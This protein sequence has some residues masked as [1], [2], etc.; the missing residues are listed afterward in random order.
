M[1]LLALMLVGCNGNGIFRSHTQTRTSE[2]E[3]VLEDHCS[4][5]LFVLR[6]PGNHN[7]DA[8][9]YR[10]VL[11]EKVGWKGLFVINKAGHSELYWGRYR[12][13][14]DKKA[15]ANL[16]T[17]KKYRTSNGKALFAGAQIVPVPGKNVGPA[18]WDLINVPDSAYYSLLVAVFRDDPKK[19][20]VGRR[21]F[22]VD[23]CRELR[24]SGYE[25][26]FY[27]GQAVSH[28]TIG[29]FGT[30]SVSVKKSPRGEIVKINDPKI[31]SLQK[32]FEFLA[33]NGRS[34]DEFVLDGKTRKRIRLPRKKTYL[35]CVPGKSKHGDQ[36]LRESRTGRR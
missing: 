30:K 5:L 22:A 4:I 36:L 23:Y 28:V 33:L 14:N 10:K 13:W 21:R 16:K 2:A 25:A 26:Y 1:L 35:I 34:I 17:A 15:E 7:Q 18:E 27:H 29:A 8:E 31:K 9:Y 12:S 6:D 24:K 11:T 19:N 20:Y 3:T 32:D